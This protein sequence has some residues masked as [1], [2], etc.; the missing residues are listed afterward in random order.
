M[1][2]PP[3]PASSQI[4]LVPATPAHQ[5]IIANLLQFYIYDFSEMM[6]LELA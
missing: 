1:P 5:Q 2:P 6:P 3:A 4:S